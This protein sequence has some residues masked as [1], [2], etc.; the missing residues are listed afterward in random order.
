MLPVF[1]ELERMLI[2][3]WVPGRFGAGQDGRPAPRPPPNAPG[4]MQARVL[5]CWA[6]GPP[7]PVP[8]RRAGSR[9]RRGR[10]FSPRRAAGR[11]RQS[12]RRER[13]AA[14]AWSL[15]LVP[16]IPRRPLENVPGRAREARGAH[17]PAH[18]LFAGHRRTQAGRLGEAWSAAGEGRSLSP[19][20]PVAVPALPTY[21]TPPEPA[22]GRPA[23]RPT[24]ACP[25]R[26]YIPTPPPSSAVPGSVPTRSPQCRSRR[27]SGAA[28]RLWPPPVCSAPSGP[29]GEHSAVA[30][31]PA[32]NE[33]T[34][35]PRSSATM[36]FRASR[37][38][39]WVRTPC[40]P[41]C[42]PCSAGLGEAQ[43][44]RQCEAWSA[45]GGARFSPL[46]RALFLPASA[47]DPR[48]HYG[49]LAE[50]LSLLRTG[51]LCHVALP[52]LPEATH[53]PNLP[54]GVTPWRRPLA[55]VLRQS[56]ACR[57]AS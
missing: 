47:P 36:G 49:L 57:P 6:D 34:H 29:A 9:S 54:G 32:A 52:P 38:S 40:E 46:P 21:P 41:A 4:V 33:R 28:R 13:R 39:P 15:C 26:G 23:I 27:P 14:A 5:M 7:P 24:P 37:A 11:S 56:P 17:R 12:A 55:A 25:L 30:P 18:L 2:H 22:G 44:G 35:V 43:A 31:R 3:G 1:A 53:E 45:G 50:A 42:E 8:P 48:H 19:I 16:P 51:G 10:P 20:P